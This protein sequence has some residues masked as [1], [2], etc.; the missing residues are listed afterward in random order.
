MK[1]SPLHALGG[2]LLAACAPVGWQ[3]PYGH[4]ARFVGDALVIDGSLPRPQRSGVLT[5]W[6]DGSWRCEELDL[7]DGNEDVVASGQLPPPLLARLAAL[8]QG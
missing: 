4:T 2:D 8:R 3:F 5:V 1:G 7:R 6:P